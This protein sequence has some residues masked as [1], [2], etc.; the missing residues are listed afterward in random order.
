MISKLEK[1][2]KEAAKNWD[3]ERAARLRDRIKELRKVL[4]PG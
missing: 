1:E 4:V 3:F 2:M